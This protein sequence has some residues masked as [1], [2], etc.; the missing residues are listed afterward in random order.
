MF[1]KF[2]RPYFA[3]V[4]PNNIL[5]AIAISIIGQRFTDNKCKLLF[6]S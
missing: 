2:I 5:R 6:F 4:G 3:R 1:I